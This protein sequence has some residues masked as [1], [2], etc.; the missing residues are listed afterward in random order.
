MSNVRDFK[1]WKLDTKSCF[2]LFFNIWLHIPDF[3]GVGVGWCC[4]KW[5]EQVHAHNS[6]CI[7]FI[8]IIL[9]LNV[10]DM[11]NVLYF[12]SG[13]FSEALISR[14]NRLTFLQIY[15]NNWRVLPIIKYDLK[16][17]INKWHICQSN[18]IYSKIW[19]AIHNY[20]N[21]SLSSMVLIWYCRH[22]RFVKL[23]PQCKECTQ[24]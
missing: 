15:N 20:L 11:S 22:F 8:K 14:Y 10:V 23:G 13:Y 12:V 7:G 16:I 4:V 2:I 1:H 9:K 19:F 18:K 5:G 3:A 17:R 6:V 24:I 21:F